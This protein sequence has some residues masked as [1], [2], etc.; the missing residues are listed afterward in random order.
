MEAKIAEP[1]LILSGLNLGSDSFTSRLH[2]LIAA[3]SF[4]EVVM[5][6]K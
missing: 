3:D 4:L 6:N 1:V 2:V 5:G